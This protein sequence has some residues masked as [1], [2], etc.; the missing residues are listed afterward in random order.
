MSGQSTGPT[1]SYRALEAQVA[2]LTRERDELLALQGQSR[3]ALM[4]ELA[5]ARSQVEALRGLVSAA[6]A[7]LTR[8]ED[9]EPGDFDRAWV[10]ACAALA[11]K[12][13]P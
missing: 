5:H 3:V 10:A 11:A 13:T 1:S 2:A 7:R 9:D 6:S 4:R 8:G 12:E